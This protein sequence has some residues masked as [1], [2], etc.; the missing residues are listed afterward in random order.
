MKKT[1]SE[2]VFADCIFVFLLSLSSVF[3]GAVSSV[4]YLCAFVLP[5][6]L[7]LC[8]HKELENKDFRISPAPTKRGLLFSAVFLFPS[9]LIIMSLSFLGGLLLSLIGAESSVSALDGNFLYLLLVHALAPAIFEEMLFRFLPLR[10][11]G[12]HSPRLAV[13]YSSVLFAFSHCN[14]VQLPYALFAGFLF[15]A[16]DVAAGSIAPSVIIHFVNNVLSLL[17]MRGGEESTFY[18]IFASVLLALSLLSITFIIIKRKSLKEK[19][20]PILTDK[21][22]VIFT[23]PLGI[24]MAM[25]LVIAS[26]SLLI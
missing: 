15:A 10:M 8:L 21:S 11:L 3:S 13:I 23:Y 9:V 12:G 24:Y 19:F 20:E 26:T 16:L 17:W 5:V 25:T 2:L 7:L 6:I 14:L 1:L 4:F 18:I 22:K